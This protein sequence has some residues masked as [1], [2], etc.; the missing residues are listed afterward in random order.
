MQ[1]LHISLMKTPEVDAS[2]N[3]PARLINLYDIFRMD[4]SV[5]SPIYLPMIDFIISNIV[6][7]QNLYVFS[8][9]GFYVIF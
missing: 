7:W 4:W 9:G 1:Y 8:R 2:P 3:T 6:L 5:S